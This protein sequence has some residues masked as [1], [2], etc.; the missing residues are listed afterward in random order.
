MS[1]EDELSC[2]TLSLRDAAFIHQHVVDAI[3]AQNADAQ[4]KPIAITFALVGL[5]L[6]VERQVSG[7]QVQLIH[8]RLAK[9]KEAWPTFPFPKDRGAITAAE[10]LATPPGAERDKA[11]DNWCE[12]VWT[13]YR[14]SRQSV[15]DLLSARGIF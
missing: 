2:Y 7:R 5:Y 8:M 3:A 14:D 9:K 13:A 11:I 6:H 10:V 12:S 15:I 4:T 1:P